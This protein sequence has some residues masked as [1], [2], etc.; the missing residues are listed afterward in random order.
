MNSCLQ[1]KKPSGLGFLCMDSYGLGSVLAVNF[2]LI[3]HPWMNEPDQ[4][5]TMYR[6]A[7]V[8]SDRVSA[9]QEHA[10]LR[11][12]RQSLLCEGMKAPGSA[13]ENDE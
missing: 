8:G 6:K 7:S 10:I 11:A 5:V 9:Q 2:T 4:C 3:P 1:R 12:V 13:A